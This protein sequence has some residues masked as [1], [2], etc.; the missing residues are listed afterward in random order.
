MPVQG[1]LAC[2]QTLERGGGRVGEGRRKG[3]RA[4]NDASVIRISASKISKQN[5]NW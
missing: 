4:C 1:A 3:K 5:A 2:E